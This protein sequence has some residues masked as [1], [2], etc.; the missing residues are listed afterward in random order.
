MKS[1]LA[2]ALAVA[3]LLVSASADAGAKASLRLKKL[4]VTI[5]LPADSSVMDIGGTLTVQ[6]GGT[7]VGVKKVDPKGYGPKNFKEAVAAMDDYSPTKVSEKKKTK[8]GW[9]IAFE[10]K[11]GMGTNYFVW[12]RKKFGG[13][14]YSCETTCS[15]P[16]QA[17]KA[18]AACHSLKK[19]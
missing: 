8:D 14:P 12:I 2:S 3:A 18:V 6:G 17:K 4:G 15:T 16:D 19:G 10:N 11:G 13:K 5:A 7:V 1:S 9:I